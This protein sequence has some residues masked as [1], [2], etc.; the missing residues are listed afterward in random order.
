MR[1]SAWPCAVSVTKSAV[2]VGWKGVGVCQEHC[3]AERVGRHEDAVASGRPGFRESLG[4]LWSPVG[5]APWES[6]QRGGMSRGGTSRG[7]MPCAGMP[8]GETSCVARR[9]VWRDAMCEAPC[10]A[11]GCGETSCGDT[12][13]GETSCG[14]TPRGEWPRIPGRPGLTQAT[15]NKTPFRLA[16]QGV[17]FPPQVYD[18]SL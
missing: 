7:G 14:E 11:T 9:P 10:G 16:S 18:R 5:M 12:S 8:C 1:F 13:R 4:S 6:A 17:K 15:Q 3:G 2:S